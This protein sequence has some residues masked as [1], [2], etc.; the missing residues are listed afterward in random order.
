M[1]ACHC[2]CMA[3]LRDKGEIGERHIVKTMACLRCK[4]RKTL[5]Q[6]PTNFKCADLICDFCGHTSQVK[7]FTKETSGLPSQILGAAWSPQKE[8]MSAG[9]YHALWL[10]RIDRKQKPRE[11]WMI[12]SEAQT[13]D[14]FIP[15]KPLS[16]SA[17]RAGWQG[18]IID[19]KTYAHLAIRMA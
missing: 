1:P 9:I 3:T 7:T 17:K 8:R 5:K 19:T 13:L 6:L 18:Y 15:R 10:V 4:R 12:S 16:S 11:I 2:E 14:L